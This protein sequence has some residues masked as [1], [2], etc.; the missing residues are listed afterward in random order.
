MT[1][2]QDEATPEIFKENVAELAGVHREIQAGEGETLLQTTDLTVKFGGLTA[3]DAVTFDIRR[4][5]TLGQHVASGLRAR[6]Q[7]PFAGGARG[8]ERGE[9]RLGDEALREEVGQH[10]VRGERIPRRTFCTTCQ[11]DGSACPGVEDE[12]HLALQPWQCII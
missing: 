7:H 10:P 1:S 2:P 11:V 4:G 5:E 8:R 3:L 12:L 6:E 9:Q